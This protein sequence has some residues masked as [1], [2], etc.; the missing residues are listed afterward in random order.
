MK[1]ENQM[2]LWDLLVWWNQ[3]FRKVNSE[4]LLNIFY[5]NNKSLFF[6]YI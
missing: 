1:M 2:K 5:V 3:R 6:V 4:M